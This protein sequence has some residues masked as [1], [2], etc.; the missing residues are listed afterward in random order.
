MDKKFIDKR[1][2]KYHKQGL[3]NK[4]IAKIFNCSLSSVN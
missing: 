1:L 2:I 3:S 4:K